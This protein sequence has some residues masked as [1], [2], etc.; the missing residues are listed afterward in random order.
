MPLP[1][2]LN[3]PLTPCG[4]GVDG[5]QDEMKTSFSWFGKLLFES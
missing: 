1:L 4:E 2:Q 3:V 5:F